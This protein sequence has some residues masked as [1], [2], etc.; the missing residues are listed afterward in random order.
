M[1]HSARSKD[2][3]NALLIG[4]NRE[5]VPLKE[6]TPRSRSRGAPSACDAFPPRSWHLRISAR[7]GIVTN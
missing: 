4:G 5:A 3:R 6:A 7:R 2:P 1:H